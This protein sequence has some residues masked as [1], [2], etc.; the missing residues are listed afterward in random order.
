MPVGG[1]VM[2]DQMQVIANLDAALDACR[3][4]LRTDTHDLALVRRTYERIDELLERRSALT[5]ANH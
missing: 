4:F 3:R 1:G 5:H 2:V